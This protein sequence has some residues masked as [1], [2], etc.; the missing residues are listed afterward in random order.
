MIC[1]WHILPDP[2]STIACVRHSCSLF[3]MQVW[4]SIIKAQF[5]YKAQ[6]YLYRMQAHLITGLFHLSGTVVPDSGHNSTLIRMQAYFINGSFLLDSNL[7]SAQNLE[8]K[9]DRCIYPRFMLPCSL[10]AENIF[11][12]FQSPQST[13][14]PQYTIG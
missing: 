7:Q 1:N 10:L 12:V 4:I 5:I 8:P 2:L 13:P 9:L 11:S 6:L 14:T 3:V